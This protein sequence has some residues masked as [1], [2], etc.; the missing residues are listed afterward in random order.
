MAVLEITCAW[1][2][3][4]LTDDS[5]RHVL[6]QIENA[7]HAAKGCACTSWSAD[8][9]GKDTSNFQF[10]AVV[11]CG[12]RKTQFALPDAYVDSNAN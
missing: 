4:R 10:D 2:D 12:C 9:S 3:D 11:R 5:R 8:V 7:A 6:R 1:R